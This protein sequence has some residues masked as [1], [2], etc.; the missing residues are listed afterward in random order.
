[1][2]QKNT[3]MNRIVS[4]F[5]QILHFA[6]SYGLPPSKKRAIVREYLQVMILDQLYQEKISAHLYF[7][8]GTSLRMVRGLDRFSEDLDFDYKQYSSQDLIELIETIYFKIKKQNIE[9][10]LYKNIKKERSYFEFRFP[11]LLFDLEIS[12]HAEEKLMI[13]F[14]FES[15][16]T[17]MQRELKLVN[18]YGYLINIV[19][20]SLNEVLVQKLTAYIQRSQTQARDL[21]DIIWLVAQGA[22]LDHDFMKINKVADNLIDQARSKYVREK[23]RLKNLKLRLQPFLLD[24]SAVEKLDLFDKVID[25]FLR[26]IKY[27]L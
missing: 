3:T 7:V 14:D 15:Q 18:R 12:Q 8:G 1:M 22:L 20:P 9:I 5:D 11:K 24:E 17:H 27:S 13:K 21:Y 23:S 10:D 19:V 6:V 26:K 25:R 4:S 2:G 16:V